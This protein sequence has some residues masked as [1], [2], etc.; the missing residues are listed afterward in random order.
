MSDQG[1]LFRREV[2]TAQ[3]QSALGSIHLATPLAHWIISGF[4]AL[5]AISLVAFLYFGHYTR[6]ATVSGELVPNAGLITLSATSRGMVSRILVH[7]DEQVTRGQ[8]LVEFDQPLDSTTLGNTH[9]IILA[10][11]QA[12]RTGLEADL[13][14]QRQLAASRRQDLLERIASLT[15]Q[16]GQIEGQ[17]RLQQQEARRMQALLAR[18]EPLAD[19]GLCLDS[20][21]AAAANQHTQCPGAGQ[22]LATPA[23]GYHPATGCCPP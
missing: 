1:R 8:P 6:R 9:A 15:A 7:Q 5:F 21:A 22:G 18:I 16:Q 23:T 13:L 12:Q 10:Q 11:L 20:G 2:L 4:V 17:Q 3:R 14:T 19:K